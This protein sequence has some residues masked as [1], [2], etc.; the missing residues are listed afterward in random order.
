[1]LAHRV[2]LHDVV[3]AHQEPPREL[4]FDVEELLRND[5]GGLH[6]KEGGS[7]ALRRL[8]RQCH[9]PDMRSYC[10]LI[11]S[12]SKISKIDE[13]NDRHIIVPIGDLG[14]GD[15]V[16]AGGGEGEGLA[17]QIADDQRSVS[18]GV[19]VLAHGVAVGEGGGRKR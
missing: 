14:D 13:G 11:I 16:R 2:P 17:R 7:G 6:P 4:S 9:R 15:R 8:P 3:L 18:V 10:Q 12:L 1:M 5:V 19:L